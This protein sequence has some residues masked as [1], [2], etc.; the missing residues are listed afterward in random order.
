[1][2]G[3]KK[4]LVTICKAMSDETRLRIINILFQ[5]TTCVCELQE[6]L[7][8][9]EPRVSRHLG[10]LKDAGLVDCEKRGKWCHYSLSL[11]TEN[12]R[13]LEYLKGKF[14]K[15]EVYK[16]DIEKLKSVNMS[17]SI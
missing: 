12:E 3:N 9:S 6:I 5:R 15:E 1:M 11:K 16:L 10:I 4:M 8:M 2:I 13:L 7:E 14:E 17:C